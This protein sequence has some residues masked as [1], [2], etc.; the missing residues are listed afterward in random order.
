VNNNHEL[1][2]PGLVSVYTSNTL[3]DSAYDL[4]SVNSY[5]DEVLETWDPTLE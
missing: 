4:Q 5:V 2:E 3:G 1:L